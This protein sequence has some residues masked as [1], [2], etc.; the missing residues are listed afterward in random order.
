MKRGKDKIM[1]KMFEMVIMNYS[2]NC[3]TET[4]YH[5]HNLMYKPMY[6]V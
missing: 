5:T 2:I 4:A 1:L 6:I 3:I